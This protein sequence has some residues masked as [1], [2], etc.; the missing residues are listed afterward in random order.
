MISDLKSS[1][2]EHL[3]SQ[4]RLEQ[5]VGPVVHVQCNTL[6][7][8]DVSNDIAGSVKPVPVRTGDQSRDFV[9]GGL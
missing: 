5:T 7:M 8:Y 2:T 3:T 1:P 6:Y 9:A 4:S